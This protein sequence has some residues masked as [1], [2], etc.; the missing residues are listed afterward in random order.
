M[1]YS[2]PSY[3]CTDFS[4]RTATSHILLENDDAT[5]E[6]NVDYSLVSAMVFKKMYPPPVALPVTT[7]SPRDT[8][9][10][11]SLMNVKSFSDITG[12][13][14]T[15]EASLPPCKSED[16]LGHFYDNPTYAHS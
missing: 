9:G 11:S 10:N 8:F 15:M 4:K 14:L 7:K 6:S 3:R 1:A 13:W 16:C 5:W 12:Q 2:S